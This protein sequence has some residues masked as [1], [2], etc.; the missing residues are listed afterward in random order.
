[1]AIFSRRSVQQLLNKASVI[2]SP[3]GLRRHLDRLNARRFNL[4]RI[5]DV[6]SSEWELAVLVALSECGQ[7]SCEV[8]FG[9]ATHPDIFFESPQTNLQFLADVRTVSDYGRHKENPVDT[10]EN[11]LIRIAQKHHVPANRLNYHIEG[12]KISAKGRKLHT[13][14]DFGSSIGPRLKPVTQDSQIRLRLPPKGKMGDFVNQNITPFLQNISQD[15]NLPSELKIDS[16]EAE[17][18]LRYD[19]KQEYFTGNY[20]S[21]TVTHSPDRNPV[22]RALEDKSKQLRK[23]GFT[24]IKGVFLCDGDCQLLKDKANASLSFSI[25]EVLWYFLKQDTTIDFVAVVTVD[26]T[27]SPA[28]SGLGN[29]IR[30]HVSAYTRCHVST[31]KPQLKPLLQNVLVTHFPPIKR[32]PANACNLLISKNPAVG[33]SFW[34]GYTLTENSIKISSRSLHMLLAGEVEYER[35]EQEHHGFGF[36]PQHNIF[37][38][39]LQSGR[40]IKSMQV[41]LCPNEDDD[42]VIIEFGPQDPAISEYR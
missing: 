34:G 41:E 24:G 27:H 6:M 29:D 2:I 15:P 22:Y 9:G 7:V 40:T 11:E 37:R 8:S 12:I 42:W 19:P 1:M 14:R 33:P 32:T 21:Y 31:A 3:G 16:N 26:E 17:I 38:R 4:Q 20:L 5:N 35:F 10:F 36:S 28:F 23:S 25:D 18:T 30:I 13:K 39:M